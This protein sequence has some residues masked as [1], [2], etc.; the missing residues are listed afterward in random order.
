MEETKSCSNCIFSANLVFTNPMVSWN[1][2]QTPFFG[3]LIGY[4]KEDFETFY[5]SKWHDVFDK[6]I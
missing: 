1:C 4:I 3:N 2:Y 6:E 5:C